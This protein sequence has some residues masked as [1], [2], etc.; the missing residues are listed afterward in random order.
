MIAM[1]ILL[2]VPFTFAQDSKPCPESVSGKPFAADQ[3]KLIEQLATLTATPDETGKPAPITCGLSKDARNRRIVAIASLGYFVDVVEQSL[4]APANCGGGCTVTADVPVKAFNS[5]IDGYTKH[6]FPNGEYAFMPNG[7]EPRP[8]EKLLF[9]AMYYASRPNLLSQARTD[10]DLMEQNPGNHDLRLFLNQYLRDANP[11]AP[12]CDAFAHP[13]ALALA[14]KN[15]SGFHEIHDG[16]PLDR[17]AL[18]D[19]DGVIHGTIPASSPPISLPGNFIGNGIRRAAAERQQQIIEAQRT[20]R[21]N[22]QKVFDNLR[23]LEN[24]RVAQQQAAND[25]L[26]QHALKPTAEP[27]VTAQTPAL[28]SIAD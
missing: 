26:S 16:T 24:Q 25:D 1:L 23:N 18:L 19:D 7:P 15:L 12:D 13:K 28:T 9:A 14:S 6:H 8:E 10:A 11:A 20:V 27:S 4:T 22:S 17:K 2:L 21:Q 5:L 3:Q